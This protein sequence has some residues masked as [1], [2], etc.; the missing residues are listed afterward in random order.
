MTNSMGPPPPKNPN[1][2]DT[3]PPSMPPPPPRDSAEPSPPPPPPPARDS[4]NAPSQGV[5]VPYKI[6]PWG[7]APCHQFYLE[8]LKDG[9]II[10]KFDVFEKGAYMFGRLDLCDF[11]LEHPTISRFHA[12]VQFKR[13]G[14]A[15]LYDLGSTHGTF[16]NK[17]QVEKNT[18]VDLHV[19]DVIR[20]GR[21]SRLFIF[22]GPSDLMPPET[23]AKLMREV[24]M[25]EAMLDKEA[26]VRR[27]RQEASLA[28]GISWGMGE[29]AIEE[30]EDDVEE[31]TWQSY[32]G[33]L[34]EKQEK[35]REKIIK[36]MEK[37][38][39]MKKEINSIRVKDIS[40]GGLTQGQQ[41]QIARNEQRIMQILE[42]LE[43]LEE[44][45]N[46]S[47]RESMGAR[48]GKLS[49]GKKKGAVEDEEEYLSDDDDDEFYDRT[50]KK[51]LHQKPGDNQVETAD[52]LLD[53]REVITKEMDEKKELLMM[54]KNKILSKSESTTQDEVDDSLDA[55]MSGLSSQL[56]HDKSEQLE[57]EL[58][59]LQ[60]E[61]DRIC[62][63]LKIADPTG[64]AAK[65]RELKVHEPKPK[66]SE[67]VIITIKKK[68]PAEA[69]KSSEPCVKADNKN[70]P[71]ETQKISETPVKEDGSIEGEKA[72]ASTL[73]LD[74]SE[75]DSDRLKAEN[76]VFAVP[77]PQW[78]GAVEDRVIDDTQQLLPSLHLHEIDESNQFVDYKDRSKILGS[79]DNANTSVESKI[80]SAAGLII[81]KR[82]QVETTATNSNDAS[83]QLTSS[84][85]GEKMAEDAVALLL[86][87]NKGLYTNDD[88]ERYEGQERR[89]PKR[90]LGPEKPSFL[91][92][93]MDYDSWVPPEG[94]SGDGRTSLNDRYGY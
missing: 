26:S 75:P 28:E 25:R 58:S 30:D 61:L 12:V 45:L 36:R 92:N 83:Q 88:E 59:T 44:T 3:A 41:T 50:N 31:V 21:S 32:K 51:P 64:E 14:D 70:P 15:Y 65:K 38:A 9:S 84:T 20:F 29:D 4:S 40:Q 72:G 67:E 27:A 19:G 13:S 85:S 68:P 78:L 54:E 86:K 56:V 82:K 74:K 43:N 33:Q 81:R 62:Y 57:K 93:E 87:H 80:E 18:Y 24:K 71:V 8:V 37:I 42:E 5:A 23:N 34:T 22:Q 7:A 11:V 89:G 6:P 49:H 63:L 48:T 55:Y 2:P 69:Q 47:I 1:P 46:D 90:V 73:G 52:T 10:D 94:Q 53:K 79:G 39:N 35:T 16:L 17:N 60:S 77:K 76:V 91:N 66:K